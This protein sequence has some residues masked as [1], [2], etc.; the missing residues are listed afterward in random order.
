M[1]WGIT[2]CASALMCMAFGSIAHAELSQAEYC[3][4]HAMGI[5]VTM[6]T[7][8]GLSQP[9]AV[10]LEQAG[11]AEGGP[12]FELAT[13]AHSRLEGGA[14]EAAVTEE[15]RAACV[16][17]DYRKLLAD[18]PTF[19][20]EGGGEAGAQLCSDLATSMSGFLAG[21]RQAAAMPVDDALDAYAPREHSETPESRPRLRM[22]MQLTQQFARR[23]PDAKKIADFAMHHCNSLDAR[24]R[25]ELDGEFYAQ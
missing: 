3:R 5:T 1:K 13:L 24:G 7:A 18:K 21:D 15:V 20:G 22:A 17:A 23:T 12:L 9:R 6:K 11:L 4:V 14:K 16:R 10:A 8:V 19:N 2:Q 25:A